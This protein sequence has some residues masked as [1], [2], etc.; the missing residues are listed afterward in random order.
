MYDAQELFKT[1]LYAEQSNSVPN[2]LELYEKLLLERADD[3]SVAHSKR[4]FLYRKE[5]TNKKYLYRL[6]T[7]FNGIYKMIDREYPDLRFSIE[8]RRK[9]AVSL[10]RKII[11]NIN[12]NKSLDSIRDTNAFRIILFGESTLELIHTCY[13][14]MNSIIRMNSKNNFTLCNVNFQGTSNSNQ[15]HPEILI[16]DKSGIADCFSFG[17]KD[18]ILF[19]KDNGY[20]SLQ[21]VFRNPNGGECFEIQVR[22]FDMHIIAESGSANH[23]NYKQKKYDNNVFFDRTRIHIPGYGISK[24]GEIFDFIGFEKSIEIL[25]RQKTF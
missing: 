18:Y 11:K 16:P 20:Q 14:V 10:D 25:K 19:P 6:R 5:I 21:C 17:V 2:F 23:F 3:A 7:I 13:D 1:A 12:T 24:A 9:G 4:L 15:M 8:G 22:T